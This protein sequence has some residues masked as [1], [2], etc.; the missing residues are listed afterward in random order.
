VKKHWHE[1]NYRTYQSIL[2][3]MRA[4]GP[5]ASK[6]FDT[7]SGRQKQWVVGWKPAK[8]LEQL[9]MGRRVDGVKTVQGLSKGVNEMFKLKGLLPEGRLILSMPSE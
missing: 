7:R 9:F 3:R 6:D 8:K 2:Q 5:S 4:R 1:K